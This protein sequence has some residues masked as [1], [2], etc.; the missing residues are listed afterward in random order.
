MQSSEV[1]LDVGLPSS[2]PCST[3][4]VTLSSMPTMR[5][6]LG[7]PPPNS[8]KLQTT[9]KDSM[10]SPRAGAWAGSLP[11]LFLAAALSCALPE[12]IF[13]V[14]VACLPIFFDI[15]VIGE[16]KAARHTIIFVNQV[17][18]I[19]IKTS[20]I[21]VLLCLQ[22][23]WGSRGLNVTN[24]LFNAGFGNHLKEPVTGSQLA[25]HRSV[26]GLAEQES[27]SMGVLHLL[28]AT[29]VPQVR[30]RGDIGARPQCRHETVLPS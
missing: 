24:K 16:A 3:H 17:D 10:M 30:R 26:F 22:E 19:L 23:K 28:M 1:I 12:A 7:L 4:I 13:N 9:L 29:T 18:A 27:G 21:Q 5:S 2:I 15:Y 20:P 14:H 25:R 6:I 8:T 11:Q